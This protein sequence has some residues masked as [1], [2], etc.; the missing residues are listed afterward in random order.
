MIADTHESLEL[1]NELVKKYAKSSLFYK[2]YCYGTYQEVTVEAYKNCA[3]KTYN[4]T[5]RIYIYTGKDKQKAFG[6]GR[7]QG[8]RCNIINN[9]L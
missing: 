9:M 6:S 5:G 1:F 2:T 7:M 3:V 8:E 4:P